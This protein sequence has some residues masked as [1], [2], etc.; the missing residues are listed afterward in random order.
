VITAGFVYN[1]A[2]LIWCKYG[3]LHVMSDDLKFNNF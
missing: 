1:T 3:M 2:V